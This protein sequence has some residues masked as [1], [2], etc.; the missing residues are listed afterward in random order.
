M[1]RN[2]SDT[3]GITIISWRIIILA[4]IFGGALLISSVRAEE[5]KTETRCE[6]M[7][8]VARHA[9]TLRQLGV[10]APQAYKAVTHPDLKK[11]VE[12]AYSRPRWLSE[13]YRDNAVA[14]FGND[15]FFMCERGQL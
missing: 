3:I 12:M 8:D 13:Q 1:K 7:A 6:I 4:A 9:M 14:D 10:S 2:T 5:P 11:V 15:V